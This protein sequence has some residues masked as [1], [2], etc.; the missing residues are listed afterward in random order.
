[1]QLKRFFLLFSFISFIGVSYGQ[2]LL[3]GTVT[4]ENG[5]PIPFAKVFVK[6]APELRTLTNVNGYFEMR[7]F[8]GE[9]YLVFSSTGYQIREAYVRIAENSEVKNIQLFP[10]KIQD[11]NDVN[12]SAKKT[13]PGREIMLK[14]VNK[15][16]SINPWKIPHTVHAYIKATENIERKEKSE[17]QKEKEKQKK[18]REDENKPFDPFDE[19]KKEAEKI[20]NNMN[21]VE[22]DLTRH[23]APRNQIKEIR[24]AYELRG[25]KRNFL[26]YTTT[27]KSNFN[28]FQNLMHLNDLH[29]TPISSPISGPGILSYKYRLIEQY[30]EDGRKINKIKIIPRNM[31]TTTLSG[32]I[33]VIDSLWLIQK[34][35]LK[36]EK[37]NL[38]VYD[39]FNITQEY[40]NRGDTLSVLT[41]QRLDYGVK[42]NSQTST[43][44]T[45]ANYDNYDF[46]PNFPPKFFNNELSS[47]EQEAYDKDTSY[48][49]KTR[50]VALTDNE[51]EYILVR[52]SINDYHNRESYHDSIDKLFNK[53]TA[54]KVLWWGIDHRN[55]AKKNQWTINSLAG[56]IRPIYIAGPRL[57]PG[58]FYFK[59]WDNE[60][61]FD[62]YTEMSI[63]ILN[64]DIK[65]STTL[66]YTY[67]PYHFGE[68][69]G[70]FSHGFDVIRTADAITQIYK[71][72]N[73]I[74]TTDLSVW[75]DY[76]IAN[77]LYLQNEFNFAERRSLED[78]KFLNGIDSVLP[79]NDP[80]AFDAYQAL[81]ISATLRFT[82]GQKYMSEPNRKVVLGSKWPMF[83][84]YYEKGI[85]SLL[86]S[87]VDHD[88]I[89]G[90]IKQTFKLGLLGTS[91]YHLKSGFFLNTRELFDAD[92]KYHR[93]SDPI[94]FSNPLESFQ[95]LDTTL[96]TQEIYFE[97]HFVHHD[98]GAIINK[99]P[100]MKKTGI[101]LVAGAGMLYVP[102]FD[103]QHYEILAGLE[104]SFKFSRRR[105]RIGIYGAISDGNNI[106]PTPTWK[107]SLALLNN[108]SMKWSF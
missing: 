65:G 38:L 44:T 4:D 41:Y 39:Y 93:R 77:G 102:E 86:G 26:Y 90:G 23:F 64:S 47:T 33:Y 25:S 34:L 87:D 35:E 12:V 101:G 45:I 99:I 19:N 13:N 30:E 71:R 108:R 37:G 83:Y 94:W 85:N 27:V 2:Q 84:I 80:A 103:W 8:E 1:M 32:Y 75:H 78:Y 107:V 28:F 60:R 46:N 105:L 70:N 18:L 53:V 91:A 52:D 49:Q 48:W 5:L 40:E 76:E 24:N 58:F 22:V 98:N 97:A 79:N 73:F 67:N 92:Q 59:K 36:M 21:L 100:F 56:F 55:R 66:E 7:L 63:G 9:Y 57:A 16:D 82:P 61:T 72:D 31:A 51:K 95:G 88:Y 42:F 106:D 17:K 14:V 68:F 50:Q 96:P 10:Q 15:R 89:L 74:E 81:I 6:N 3:I 69:G 62:S 104:R 20:A 43:C 54:L 29:Q 11:I